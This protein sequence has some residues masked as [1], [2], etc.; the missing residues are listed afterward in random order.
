MI[1]AHWVTFVDV[2]S[3]SPT[4]LKNENI[5]GEHN[6]SNLAGSFLMASHLFPGNNNSLKEAAETFKAPHNRGAWVRKSGK[7][8]FAVFA[9][10]LGR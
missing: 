7:H 4:L 3:D 5:L 8:F 10:R 1:H 9:G 6:F 2:C